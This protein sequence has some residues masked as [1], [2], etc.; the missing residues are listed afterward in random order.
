MADFV[1]A[2]GH[3]IDPAN[4]IDAPMDV[5][6]RDGLVAAVQAPGTGGSGLRREDVAGAI[7]T[8][9]FVDLHGHWYEGSAWGIDPIGNLKSGVTT[10]C[11]AGSTGYETFP[12]FRKR[13]V[14]VSPV[15]LLVFLHIGSLGAPSMNAGELEDFR[16]VRVPD[17]VETIN[18]NRD[19][20]VGIKVRLGTQPCGDN[21]M[22]ALAATLEAA[23]ATGLPAIVHVSAGAELSRVMPRLRPGDIVTHTFNPEDG[24]L[25]FGGGPEILPEVRAAQERGVI[26]DVGHGC[27]SFAWSIHRRAA[28]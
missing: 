28:E 11:D 7:V 25:I 24:G 21:I 5:V 6:V 27:G 2:G 3:V 16:Y 12:E 10:P 15:R 17:A 9:G 13:T 20:I 1:L 19:V 23:D 22:R 14:D 26:F 4:G 8:P 18:R